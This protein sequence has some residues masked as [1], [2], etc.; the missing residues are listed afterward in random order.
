M[1]KQSFADKCIPKQSLGTRKIRRG[2][3][4]REAPTERRCYW[5]RQRMG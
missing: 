4:T 2:A 5:S 1:T 3:A